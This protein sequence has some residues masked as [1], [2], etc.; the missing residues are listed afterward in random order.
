MSSALGE[1]P[2]ETKYPAGRASPEG[3]VRPSGLGEGV[4]GP[5]GT[6]PIKGIR[7]AICSRNRGLRGHQ[8]YHPE[9]DKMSIMRRIRSR[10]RSGVLTIPRAVMVMFHLRVGDTVSLKLVRK[11]TILLRMVRPQPT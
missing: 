1:T 10:G 5:A 4:Y 7:P 8:N 3:K 2:Q 6:Y 11:A 9:S